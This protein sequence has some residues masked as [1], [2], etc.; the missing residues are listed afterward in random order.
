MNFHKGGDAGY[1]LSPSVL[2]EWAQSGLAPGCDAQHS[3]VAVEGTHDT[4]LQ[5]IQTGKEEIFTT[6]PQALFSAISYEK[7]GYECLSKSE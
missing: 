5:G 7:V 2:W 3:A 4:A 1:G 6:N